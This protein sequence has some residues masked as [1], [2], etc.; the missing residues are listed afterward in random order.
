MTQVFIGLGTNLEDRIANISRAVAMFSKYGNIESMSSVY[1]TEPEGLE[2]Q[3]DY[4]NCVIKAVV[5]VDAV[6]LL[7]I[8]KKIEKEM[9]RKRGKRNGPRLIDLD[10]LFYSS[11]VINMP[12][13]KVPHPRLEERAFVLVPMVEIAR[14]FVHPVLHKSMLQLLTELESA[15][16]VDKCPDV[17][18]EIKES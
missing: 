6:K 5:E 9:G 13:L 8:L 16:R 12:D 3:P 4:L 15:S 7:A 18:I 14:G 17:K 2:E 11:Q 10:L 1:E